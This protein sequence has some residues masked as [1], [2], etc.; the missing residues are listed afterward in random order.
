MSVMQAGKAAMYMSVPRRVIVRSFRKRQAIALES[1]SSRQRYVELDALRGIA[2]LIVVFHHLSLAYDAPIIWYPLVAGHESVILF[3][4]LSGFVLSL[5]FWN[6]GTNGAYVP[7]LVRRFFRIYI[8]FFAAA[9]FALL[10]GRHFLY[11]TL[12]LNAW[13]DL[14][15]QDDI[16]PKF[17]LSQMTMPPNSKLNTAFWSLRYEMEMSI[18]FP[19]CLLILA[20]LRRWGA[21]LFSLAVYY[22]GVRIHTGHADDTLRYASVFLLGATLASQTTVLRRFWLRLPSVVRGLTA[23]VGAVLY[24]YGSRISKGM[25]RDY[26]ADLIVAFGSCIVITAAMNLPSLSRIL[27]HSIPEYLGRV[28]YSLYLIH[29]T[30]LF[31]VLNSLHGRMP[32]WVQVACFLSLTFAIT[33]IFCVL[34]EEPALRMGKKVAQKLIGNSATERTEANLATEDV[35]VLGR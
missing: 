22:L 14:T 1:R 17:V 13:F 24:F 28:S 33:H 25:H 35:A 32:S 12:H 26:Y 29:G 16:T 19:L 18:I 7:Y 2:A 10:V 11:S 3:F 15:W 31:A 20:K 34:V 4:A 21:L 6:K 27:R 9:I 5:P 30:I 23:L 8:P